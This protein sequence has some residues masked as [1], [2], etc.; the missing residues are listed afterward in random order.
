M[1]FRIALIGA[2]E[3]MRKKLVNLL[4]NNN[5]TV[6]LYDPVNMSSLV[7]YNLHTYDVIIANS[8]LAAVLKEDTIF[9]A[10]LTA[11]GFLIFEEKSVQ[12]GP[13][14][15][16]L[17][18][19]GM[20]QE[21][22]IAKINNIVYLNTNTRKSTRMKVNLP[23]EYEYEGKNYQS[24]LHDLSERGGFILTL[25]PPSNGTN[26]IV[27]FSLPG[28]HLMTVAECR[29]IYSIK[30]NLD[31][32][33]IAHPSSCDQKIISLPGV[34]IVFEQISGNNREA[35]KNFIETHQ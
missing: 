28:E 4:Q 27:R 33:I 18:H 9:N 35:I 23:V 1:A 19:A 21:D 29:V 17:I 16:F 6:D 11:A 2:S 31:Q 32:Q 30:C 3:Q 22:I 13:E 14:P 20:S 8:S 12:G 15:P 10:L 7:D 24:T 25:V 34:G 26:I 5:C